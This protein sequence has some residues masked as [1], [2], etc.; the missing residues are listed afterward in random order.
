VWFPKYAS[1]LAVLEA[2]LFAFPNGRHDNQVDSITQA[3]AHEL[4]V[5][6][7]NKGNVG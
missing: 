7:W 5:P 3:L 6:L 4:W 1:W 2:E